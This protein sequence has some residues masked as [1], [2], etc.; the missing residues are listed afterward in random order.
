M[1]LLAVAAEVG[2]TALG[3]EAVA[4]ATGEVVAALLEVALLESVAK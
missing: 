4:L 3:V 2:V 1:V